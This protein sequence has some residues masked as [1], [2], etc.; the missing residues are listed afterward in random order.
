MTTSSNGEGYT[1]GFGGAGRFSHDVGETPTAALIATPGGGG[2]GYKRTGAWTSLII[3][4]TPQVSRAS[5]RRSFPNPDCRRCCF[6][7]IRSIVI[8][9]I[10]PRLLMPEGFS[11][12]SGRDRD[13]CGNSE[14][15]A[16]PRGSGSATS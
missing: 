13:F 12:R 10:L 9:E 1:Y 14:L 7:G 5:E 16:C 11:A 3:L 4:A 8:K 2:G 15:A 6:H